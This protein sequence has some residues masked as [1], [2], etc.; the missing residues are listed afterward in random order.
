M[1]YALGGPHGATIGAVDAGTLLLTLVD[2]SN[3][4]WLPA[5]EGGSYVSAHLYRPVG[6]AEAMGH[7]IDVGAA[8]AL[9]S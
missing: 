9:G 7:F 2:F 1:A 3:R 8:I 4:G 6:G 5:S